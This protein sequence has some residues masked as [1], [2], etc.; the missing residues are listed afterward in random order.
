LF[1]GFIGPKL[2]VFVA[3]LFTKLPDCRAGKASPLACLVSATRINSS[4]T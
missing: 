4:A 3:P 2:T 1:V